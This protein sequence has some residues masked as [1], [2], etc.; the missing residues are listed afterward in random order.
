MN[1]DNLKKHLKQAIDQAPIDLLEKIKAQPA[2]KMAAHDDITRQSASGK[3]RYLK[4]ALALLSAAAIFLIA[5]VNWQM[6]TQWV[7]SMVYLD[8]NPS[9]ALETNRRDQVIRLS[10]L[11]DESQALIEGLDY[12]GKSLE[13]VAAELLDRLV[14]QGYVSSSEP[15]I[16]LS[17]FNEDPEKRSRQLTELDQAIHAYLKSLEIQPIV[18]TQTLDPTET[19]S[20]YAEANHISVSKM[21]LIRNMIL[22]DPDLKTEDLSKLSLEAL[23]KVSSKVELNLEQIIQSSDMERIKTLDDFDEDD[24]EDLDDDN[25]DGIDDID[26]DGDLDDDQDDDDYDFDDTDDNDT[27]DDAYDLDDSED[28]DSLED[29][30]DEVED[31]PDDIDDDDMEDD[32]T[33]DDDSEDDD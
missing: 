22:L 18:L 30:D 6:T 14:L 23:I 10:G 16:L 13:T 31:D 25:D 19:L 28:D 5:F 33:E 20:E 26:D 27:M 32:D 2:E 7:D 21:T 29:L 9:L 12:K 24:P 11:D 1:E 4:P 15:A 3:V 8:V 17:V